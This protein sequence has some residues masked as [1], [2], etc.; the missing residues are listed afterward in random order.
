M[1]PKS[2]LAISS[3][4]IAPQ[5]TATKAWGLRRDTACSAR[6]TCSLPVPVSPTSRTLAELPA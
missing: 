6:A 3:G 5:L 2:S 4:E 1:W